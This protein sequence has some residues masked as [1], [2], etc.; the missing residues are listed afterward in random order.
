MV[1]GKVVEKR[2]V[3]GWGGAEPRDRSECVVRSR[4]TAMPMAPSST[5]V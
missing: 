5:V 4:S 2:G 1:E 3:E